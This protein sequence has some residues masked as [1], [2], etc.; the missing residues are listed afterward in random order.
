M[1]NFVVLLNFLAWMMKLFIRISDWDIH[2]DHELSFVI[3]QELNRG[4]IDRRQIKS[5]HIIEIKRTEVNFRVRSKVN[6]L[7]NG[8][9]Y[10]KDRLKRSW[11]K[12]KVICHDSWASKWA[13]KDGIG[14]SF[15]PKWTVM[16]HKSIVPFRPVLSF[17]TVH[18][19]I[20]GP[21]TFAYRPL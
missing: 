7:S 12:L 5:Q 1:K 6:G 17:W 4:Y 16:A 13:I 2:Y 10:E 18:D 3:K 8:R 9:S 11:V 20:L 15:G 21:S 19:L 14:G